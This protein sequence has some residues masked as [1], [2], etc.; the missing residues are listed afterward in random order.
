MGALASAAA[1]LGSGFLASLWQLAGSPW[2]LVPVAV[3]ALMLAGRWYLGRSSRVTH[4]VIL[5][6]VPEVIDDALPMFFERR[7]VLADHVREAIEWMERD[8]ERARREDD[9][10]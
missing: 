1:V 10:A 4:L 2:A 7:P 8:I 6:P 3:A 9:R 5:P